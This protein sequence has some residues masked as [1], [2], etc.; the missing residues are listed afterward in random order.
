MLYPLNKYLA[1]EPVCEEEEDKSTVLVPEGVELKNTSPFCTVR[2]LE[3]NINSTLRSGMMLVAPSHMVEKVEIQDR[4][5]Y[6]LLE[7]QVVGF[8]GDDES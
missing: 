7:S 2:L 8:I 4:T 6:L 3:P 1:V 5:Y